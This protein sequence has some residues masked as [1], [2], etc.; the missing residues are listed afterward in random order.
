MTDPQPALELL[1]EGDF[2]SAT[3]RRPGKVAACAF[4]SWCPFC[5]EFLPLFRRASVPPGWRLGLI[6][7]SDLDSPLWE[8]LSIEVTPSLL[9][10]VDGALAWRIDGIRD[11]GLSKRDLEAMRRKM[12]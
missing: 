6:D 8:R 12:S 10:F 5:D 7:V 2:D 1:T 3:L 9:G 11:V 4:A